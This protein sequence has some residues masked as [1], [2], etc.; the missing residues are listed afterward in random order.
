MSGGADATRRGGGR[1]GF[2]AGLTAFGVL[3]GVLGASAVGLRLYLELAGV[4]L[5]KLGIHAPGGR[6]VAAVPREL[7]GWVQVGSDVLLK[8]DA[9]ETLGTGNYV[10]RLFRQKDGE[11]ASRP[12]VVDLHM[13]YYTDEIDPVPHV[14]ERCFVGG[15]WQQ[16]KD[17]GVIDIP[18]E[19]RGWVPDESTRGQ[20]YA[21]QQGVIYTVRLP[22]R[23]SDSPGSRVRLPRDVGPERPLAMKASEFVNGEQRIFAGYF[24]IANGGA[25]ARASDVRALAFDRR[26]KYAFYLKVQVTSTTV[27]SGEELAE[28]AGDLLG[29]MIGEVM[30]VVPDW[31][32]VSR[33]AY[34]EA[35][36]GAA[37]VN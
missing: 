37:L 18:M 25:A 36:D 5:Q 26:N 9:Q 34:P 3:F 27:S 33:G 31:V 11:D 22:N 32:E 30:R 15:G 7:S 1:S 19:T 6:Q 16:A 24:F 13:A 23:W 28:V 21:G 14:P 17:L 20:D 29:E 35:D 10:S 4:Q 12:H 2:V 8:K